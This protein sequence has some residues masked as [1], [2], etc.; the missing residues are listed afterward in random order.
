MTVLTLSILFSKIEAVGHT[1]NGCHA[2]KVESFECYN[3]NMNV[4]YDQK[5]VV[6]V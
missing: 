4:H 3:R 5:N 1:D 6:E 2:T